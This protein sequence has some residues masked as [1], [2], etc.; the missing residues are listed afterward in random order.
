MWTI[1]RWNP[2]RNRLPR[3]PHGKHGERG[4]LIIVRLGSRFGH[5][6]RLLVTAQ[7]Q[8]ATGSR[9]GPMIPFCLR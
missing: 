1:R 8:K 6:G 9:L 2:G 4:G 5:P 3:C 7:S